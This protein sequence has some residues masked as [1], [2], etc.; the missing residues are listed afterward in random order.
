MTIVDRIK[1]MIVSGGFNIYPVE[2][3][4]VIQGHPAVLD[5]IV[6]GV[7]DESGARPSRPWCSSSR[8]IPSTTTR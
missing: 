7:P 6:I 1:D 2:I 3:E 5:C 4:K 8:G